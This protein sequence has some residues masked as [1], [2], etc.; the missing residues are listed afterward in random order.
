MAPR[1]RSVP[2]VSMGAVRAAF[3]FG[4]LFLIVPLAILVAVSFHPGRFMTFPP[5][6]FSMRWYGTLFSSAQWM[7]AIQTSLVVGVASAALSTSI[8]LVLALTLDRWNIRFGEAFRRLGMLPLFVP[9]VIMGVAFVAFFH[10]L[11]LAGRPIAVILAHGIFNAPFPLVLITS[12]LA[13]VHRE[14]EE[15][16]MNLGARPG[17]VLRTVTLPLIRADVFAGVL[18]AFILSLNEY[19]VAF[20][21]AGFTV[22]TLPI[23][24]FSSLRY[25]Y[26]PVIAAASVLFIV[27]TGLLVWAADRAAGGLWD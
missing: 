11:G 27:G 3:W 23:E 1:R 2:D 9:P 21:V 20:L 17:A 24:I 8:A 26:S 18:F 4:L 12:G 5:Q 10:Q 25:S 16:A 15:S 22:V 6:G 13:K 19:I 7:G 14:L